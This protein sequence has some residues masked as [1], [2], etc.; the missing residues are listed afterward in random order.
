LALAIDANKKL[1]AP[2]PE[3]V[4]EK[5]VL[6]SFKGVLGTRVDVIITGGAP[7]SPAVLDFLKRY[8]HLHFSRV[9]PDYRYRILMLTQ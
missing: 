1:E 8:K 5:E 9:C 6:K 3:G 4:I 2:Q 7:T